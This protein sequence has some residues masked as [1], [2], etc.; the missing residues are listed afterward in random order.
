[1]L[2][3]GKQAIVQGDVIEVTVRFAMRHGSRCE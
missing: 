3:R 1:M 2:R